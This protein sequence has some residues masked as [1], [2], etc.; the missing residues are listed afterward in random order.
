MILLLKTPKSSS[1]LQPHCSFVES[2]PVQG[3]PVD[4]FKPKNLKSPLET[5][6]FIPLI[7]CLHFI[8]HKWSHKR[9]YLANIRLLVIKIS[10][11]KTWFYD[12]I[13]TSTLRVMREQ[14]I[15]IKHNFFLFHVFVYYETTEICI[16]VCRYALI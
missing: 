9:S 12:G 3:T 5:A 2:N 11:K 13:S 7:F 10:Y 6:I 15:L 16:Y 1:T 4:H 8:I 14:T